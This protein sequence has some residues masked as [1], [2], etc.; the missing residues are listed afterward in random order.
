M[1]E[2]VRLARKSLEYYLVDGEF[3]P[4]PAGLPEE[5]IKLRGGVFVSLKK[6]G[7]LRGCIG[8]IFG[9]TGSIAEEIIRNAVSAALSDPRFPKVRADE[10]PEL[11]ISVD[12]LGKPFPVADKRLLDPLRYGVIVTLGGRQGLLLPNLEGVDTVDDQIMIAL[13]KAG[14]DQSEDYELSAFEVIRHR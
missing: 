2:Y 12:V 4:V 8:T 10:L 11:E 13:D 7:R 1:D 3:L 14:I 9:I 5:M 6:E